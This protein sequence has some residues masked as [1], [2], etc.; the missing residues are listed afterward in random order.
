LDYIL[1]ID[2][3]TKVCSVALSK[4]DNLIELIELDSDDLSHSEKLHLFIEK[5]LLNSAIK[6]SDLSAVCVSKGPGSYTGLRIGVSAAKGLCYGLNIPLIAIDTLSAMA[7]S[8]AHKVEET[9]TLIPMIDAR[10]IEVFCSIHQSGNIIKSV[11]S[12][13][14]DEEPFDDIS[15]KSVY[16]FG[17]GAE[18][19]QEYVNPKWTYLPEQKTSA[20]N[21]I[22]LAF[23]KFQNQDFEDTAYFE[24]YYHKEFKAGKPKKILR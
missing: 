13:I 8:V 7:N 15:T 6:P 4:E 11:H 17:D 3:T 2:S 20:K 14:L 12:R 16:Y 24:P 9:A 23:K 18:K 10:R 1:H 19:A 21:L 5:C 22:P